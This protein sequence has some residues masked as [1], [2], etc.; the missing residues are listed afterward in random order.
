[1][2]KANTH[3]SPQRNRNSRHK[4][5]GMNFKNK[6][7]S[8]NKTVSHNR[9]KNYKFKTLVNKVVQNNRNMTELKRKEDP[10]YDYNPPYLSDI[11][12]RLNL[13]MRSMTKRMTVINH[14]QLAPSPRIKRPIVTNRKSKSVDLA[15]RFKLFRK[16]FKKAQKLQ[17]QLRK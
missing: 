17:S 10:F 5:T 16:D 4:I 12:A 1:M 7:K 15:S 3:F 13:A 11:K 2:K 9:P 6:W 14:K 8:F